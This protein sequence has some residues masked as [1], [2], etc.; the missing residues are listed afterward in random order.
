[1]AQ[2]QSSCEATYE[3]DWAEVTGGRDVNLVG[4]NNL[5]AL[6]SKQHQREISVAEFLLFL[7]ETGIQQPSMTFKDYVEIIL[8]EGWSTVSH[9][10]SV[11]SP[12]SLMS[13]THNLEI[14][15]ARDKAQSEHDK[16]KRQI[17][18]V[19]AAVE[20]QKQLTTTVHDAEIELKDC[21]TSC[22]AQQI[23]EELR[24]HEGGSESTMPISL[25]LE[26]IH[27]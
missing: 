16:L 1:M 14:S 7:D 22:V 2:I 17:E 5:A 12:L 21:A 9:N 11:T 6:L 13:P 20:I 15:A 8:G 26:S 24:R 4:F 3:S 25:V 23:Q 10:T 18:H 19:E 27:L